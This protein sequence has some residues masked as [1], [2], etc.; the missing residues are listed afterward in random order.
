MKA[1]TVP[2]SERKRTNTISISL[3]TVNA[4]YFNEEYQEDIYRSQIGMYKFGGM[5]E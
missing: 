5:V 4:R 2:V 1:Q 3:N